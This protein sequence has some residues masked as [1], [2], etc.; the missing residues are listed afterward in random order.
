[1]RSD[2]P[3]PDDYRVLGIAPGATRM[4]IRAAFLRL[5]REHHPDC[6]VAPDA[7]ERFV[8]IRQAYEALVG[9]RHR[10]TATAPTAQPTAVPVT[11]ADVIAAAR[12]A[13]RGELG[14]QGFRVA[15][16]GFSFEIG[17]MRVVMTIG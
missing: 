12:A 5:A 4:E 9:H 2:G 10:E 7:Q 15:S 11:P 8:R 17:G 13:L 3:S 6:S 14:R 16:D 1:M